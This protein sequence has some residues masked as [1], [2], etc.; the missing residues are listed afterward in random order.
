MKRLTILMAAVV[1]TIAATMSLQKAKATNPAPGKP[2]LIVDQKRLLQNWVLRNEKLS[3]AACSVEEGGIT[4]AQLGER[5]AQAL[6]QRLIASLGFDRA[7]KSLGDRVKG[8][9]GR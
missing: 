6:S 1:L 3:A 9:F 5:V 4:P 7:F 2:D 8:V